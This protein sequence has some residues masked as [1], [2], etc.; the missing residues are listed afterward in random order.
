MS[1][2]IEL[3][4][5]RARLAALDSERTTLEARLEQLAQPSQVSKSAP[6]YIAGPVTDAST[7]AAKLTLFNDLF[8]GRPDVFPVRWENTRSGRSGYAPACAS[9]R[10]HAPTSG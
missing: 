3:R 1:H 6:A 9:M 5:L 4:R 7:P 2:D 8:A 10:Q